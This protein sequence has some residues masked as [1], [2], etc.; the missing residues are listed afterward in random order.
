MR[1]KDRFFLSLFVTAL[2]AFSAC[3]DPSS[4]G[5]V[6]DAGGN[7]IVD[8]LPISSFNSTPISGVNSGTDRILMGQVNDPVLGEITATGYLDFTLSNRPADD[9]L[10]GEVDSLILNLTLD[11]LYTYGNSSEP[12]TFD[13][14]EISTAYDVVTEPEEL[15]EQDVIKLFEFS[16][17]PGTRLVSVPFPDDWIERNNQLLRPA[18]PEVF[19][20]NAFNTDF[21]GLKFVPTSGN[22]FIRIL[23]N[24]TSSFLRGVEVTADTTDTDPFVN[25]LAGNSITAYDQITEPQLPDQRVLLHSDVGANIEFDLDLSQITDFAGVNRAALEVQFDTTTF[26]AV[27]SFIRPSVGSLTLVGIVADSLENTVEALEACGVPNVSVCI[28]SNS[29]IT[30]QSTFTFDDSRFRN[31]VERR[32]MGLDVFKHYE[33]RFPIPNA[34]NAIIFHDMNSEENPPSFI[35]TYTVLN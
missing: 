23:G 24:S 11:T 27:E 3:E 33:I 30:N 15:P 5:L 19:S 16:V 2:L 20:E 22:A 34:A 4:V 10:N 17:T 1:I 18:I 13:V 7:A 14:Y 35:L 28:L 12:V 25:Y 32:F 21:H 26:S 6:D 9:Y 8:E 31:E 29:R